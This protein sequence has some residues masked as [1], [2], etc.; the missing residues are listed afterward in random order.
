MSKPREIFAIEEKR[1]GAIWAFSTEKQKHGFYN[2]NTDNQIKFIEYSAY[3]DLQGVNAKNFELGVAMK[4]KYEKAVAR[5]LELSH[6]ILSAQCYLSG[7][8]S[9]HADSEFVL[10]HV[11]Q[12]M[13]D[14]C[15]RFN[16][17]SK[18]SDGIK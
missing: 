18:D 7:I 5:E 14:I 17:A 2:E 3:I 1:S 10:K 8:K 16:K 15:S 13:D 4:E 11:T 9:L 12:A 6:I